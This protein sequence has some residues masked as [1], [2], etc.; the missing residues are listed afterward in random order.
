MRRWSLASMIVGTGLACGAFALAP[1]AA[2]DKGTKESQASSSR[3]REGEEGPE[4]RIDKAIEKYESRA[5][6]D[7]EQTRKD[8]DGL[9]KELGELVDL[10][11]AMSIS[12]AELQAEMRA[13][14]AVVEGAT[15]GNA[16]S[17]SGKSSGTADQERRRLRAVELTRELRQVQENL[18]NVVQQKRNETDQLVAQLR[19]LRAQQRQMASERERNK[20][21]ANQDKD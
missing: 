15:G 4:K 21:A 14:A 8:V 3:D 2:E 6:Q 19:N 7:L 11:F 16:D 17:D 10:Q 9:K 1:A 5:E 12:L 18:R 20:Q 13:Q